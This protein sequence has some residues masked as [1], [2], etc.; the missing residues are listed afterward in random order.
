MNLNVEHSEKLLVDMNPP[1]FS[2]STKGSNHL[3]FILIHTHMAVSFFT[4]PGTPKKSFFCWFPNTTN[5]QKGGGLIPVPLR[6]V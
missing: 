4:V 3:K 1:R 5:P 2:M 6:P